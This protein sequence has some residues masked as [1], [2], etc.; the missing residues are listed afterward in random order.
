MGIVGGGFYFHNMALPIVANAANP[1]KT[2]RNILIGFICVFMTYSLV[3]V[4]GVYGFSGIKFADVAP[5]TNNIQE[6]CLN[7]LP[8]DSMGA[9]LIRLCIFC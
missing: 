8:S 9:T 2:P 6:N 1:K 5:S 7:Q 3:G 4:A